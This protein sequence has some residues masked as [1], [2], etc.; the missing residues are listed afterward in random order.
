VAQIPAMDIFTSASFSDG[1][2]IGTSAKNIF[3]FLK[4]TAF[5]FKHSFLPLNHY[6]NHLLIM[7][8]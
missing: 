7:L 4:Q 8:S 1:T 2:G 3:L 5:I 6:L